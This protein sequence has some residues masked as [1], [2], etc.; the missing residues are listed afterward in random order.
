MTLSPT[1][2][3][4]RDA[5]AHDYPLE[6]WQIRLLARHVESIGN[7]NSATGDVCLEAA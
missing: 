1:V 2:S 7:S 3:S 4:H 5:P 6:L